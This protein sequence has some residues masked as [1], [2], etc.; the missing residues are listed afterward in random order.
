MGQSNEELLQGLLDREAIRE[1]MYAYCRGIDRCDEAA[2]R[3]A[4]WEDATDRHGAYS[5]SANGFIDYAV[6]ARTNGP[7][8]IHQVSNISIVLKGSDAAVESYFQAFQYDNDLEGKLRETFL[9]G[10]YVDH[11]EK[12]GNEWRIAARTVIYDWL[13]ESPGPAGEE[14]ERFGLRSPQGLM[15]PHD[16]WYS[17]AGR[18][19]F[20]D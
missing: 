13:K 7:R 8:M 18:A 19:P 6:K 5:G 1:A 15:K 14:A 10:R 17:L 2:L 9:C 11:F 3:S 4:Y 12:R 16:A 20:S